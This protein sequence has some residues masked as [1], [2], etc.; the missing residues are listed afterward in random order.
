MDDRP[1]LLILALTVV[2]LCLL[3]LVWSTAFAE[4]IELPYFT[5]TPAPTMDPWDDIIYPP[6]STPPAWPIVHTFYMP[7][8]FSPWPDATP[9]PFPIPPGETP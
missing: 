7:I 4:E 5:P 6:P 8:V 9:M 3:A 1:Y 2:A